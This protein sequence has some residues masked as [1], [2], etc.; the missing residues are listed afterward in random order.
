MNRK[1]I[2]FIHGIGP[3]DHG[4]SDI[5]WKLLWQGE[6]PEDARKYEL[7]YY[8][9]FEDMN[10]KLEVDKF[11]Q[12][13]GLEKIINGIMGNQ[14]FSDNIN[15]ILSD[16]VSH[17]LY[18]L[19]VPDVYNVIVR[20]F[21]NKLNNVLLEAVNEGFPPQRH[22]IVIISHS[23][24][25]VVAYCGLHHA[26]AELGTGIQANV[27]IKTLFSLATPLELIKTV[28]E[29][30]KIKIQHVSDGI[31]KPK[32]WDPAKGIYIKY[33]K[34]WYSYRHK[35]DP[36]ASL[37]PL[38]GA[39]LDSADDSPFVFG[40]LPGKDVHDYS[41]YIKQSRDIILGQIMED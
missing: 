32:E 41:N 1:S 38:K 10:K 8:D 29:K 4:Y 7:F 19:L 17:V 9:I 30:I 6:N 13:Y 27:R 31:D 12:N 20:L 2:V 35:F 14:S 40:Q 16:T 36:V 26:M 25:T 3:Q 18:F 39:F 28:G 34:K 23:L 37:I 24:G 11:V 33:L 5:S 15:K 22:D 21:V